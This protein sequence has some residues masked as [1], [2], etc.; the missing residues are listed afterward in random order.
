MT[1]P[2]TPATSPGTDP[3]DIERRAALAHRHRGD[4]RVGQ[5]EDVVHVL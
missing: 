3:G 5:Q 1:D 2:H 4:P